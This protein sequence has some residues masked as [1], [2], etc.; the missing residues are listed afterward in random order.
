[1]EELLNAVVDQMED[2]NPLWAYAFLLL[3]AFLGRAARATGEGFAIHWP[4]VTI[5]CLPNGPCLEAAEAAA[6]EAERA[7]DVTIR[8]AAGGA[9]GH[10]IKPRP[11]SVRVALEDWTTLKALAARTYVPA[12]AESRLRGAGAGLRDND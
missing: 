9:D 5:R 8:A 11:T 7:T 2:W 6:L 12:T 4:G 3:S 1:M 10:S